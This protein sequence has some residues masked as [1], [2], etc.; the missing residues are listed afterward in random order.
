MVIEGQAVK[1]GEPVAYLIDRDAKL[2]VRQAEADLALRQAE[3]AGAE[4]RSTAAR[5]LLERADPP[6]SRAGRR[7]SA[8]R[9]GR[10]RAGPPAAADRRQPRPAAT[11][12]SR[13]SKASRRPAIGVPAIMLRKAQSEL[14]VATAELDDHHK[15]H[16]G[17]E[18]RAGRAANAPRRAAAQLELKTDE[19]R[20]VAEAHG[21]VAAA[22]GPARAGR[23][24]ARSRAGC[25]WSGP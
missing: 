16:A 10:N 24:G 8:A 4:A 22:E 13:T 17:P 20:A 25:G 1:A 19:Q 23:C 3:L 21:Q 2:A 6:A 7:R 14:E 11:L 12:P 18:A 5:K 15:H 9:P